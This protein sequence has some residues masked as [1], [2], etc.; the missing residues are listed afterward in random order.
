MSNVIPQRMTARIDGD[1]VVFLIGMRINK[2]WK[3]WKWGPVAV[4]PELG[5][6]HARTH[7]GLP[8]LMVV[9]Y[10]RSFAHLEKYATEANAQHLPAWRAFNRAV[11]SNGD[12]G[13]WHETYLVKAGAYESVYN[14]MPPHGLGLAGSLEPAQGRMTSAKDRLGVSKETD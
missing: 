8:N 5:L 11:G 9:Q 13:I 10:W 7:F 12:V 14:N 6:L 1:F 4:Q 3:V 2:P